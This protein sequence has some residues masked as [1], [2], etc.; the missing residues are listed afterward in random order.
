M[1]LSSNFCL[2]ALLALAFIFSLAFHRTDDHHFNPFL[3]EKAK[4]ICDFKVLSIKAMYSIN[5]VTIVL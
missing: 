4:V 3:Y 2:N 1:Y 5:L